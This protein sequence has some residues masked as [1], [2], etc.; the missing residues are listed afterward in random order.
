M[1]NSSNTASLTHTPSFLVIGAGKSGT[2]SVWRY[3]DQ[4]PEVFMSP[5]KE[6]NFFALEGMSLSSEPDPKRMHHYP[7]SVTTW[8]DY[9]A[10]FADAPPTLVTGEVSPMYLYD[11][12][13]PSNIVNHLG[14]DVR[15]IAFLRQPAERLFSRWQ[16]LVA[17]G[18]P[19]SDDIRDAFDRSSIWWQRPDLVPE[20]FYGNHLQ[21]YVERFPR[22]HLKIFLFEEL[23]EHPDATLTALYEFIGVDPSFTPV[24]AQHNS[25]HRLT[26]PVL[27]WL[28]GRESPLKQLLCTLAPSLRHHPMANQLLAWIRQRFGHR[29]VLSPD[30]RKRLTHEIYADDIR[31]LESIL[32]RRLPQ[33]Y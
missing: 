22:S 13:A 19:P 1:S 25:S 32:D 26:H 14:T 24:Q 30:L 2:T 23:V 15:L 4:H 21:R 6:P 3:L 33:W 8:E 10:L 16:H 7:Q 31:K 28:F 17:D 5:V 18:H 12:R 9:Q 29:E 27:D 20:G 11:D